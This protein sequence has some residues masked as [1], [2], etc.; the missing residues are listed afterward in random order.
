MFAS[1]K[2]T[3]SH[4]AVSPRDRL[5]VLHTAYA[6]QFFRPVAGVVLG[7]VVAVV[8]TSMAS[9]SLEEMPQYYL[10]GDLAKFLP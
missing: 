7:A 3:G 6:A 4:N 10:Y 2:I 1:E 5:T 8:R 9:V